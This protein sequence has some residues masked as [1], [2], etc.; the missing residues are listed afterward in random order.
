MNTYQVAEYL[1]ID[2]HFVIRNITFGIWFTGLFLFDFIFITFLF[3]SFICTSDS[4]FF[5]CRICREICI[6]FFSAPAI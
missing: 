1:E 5:L 6:T 3:F 4:I 2:N